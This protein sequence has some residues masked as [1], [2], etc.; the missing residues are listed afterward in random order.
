MSA[1]RAKDV[2][3]FAGLD[4]CD[5]TAFVEWIAENYARFG[6]ALE[7]VTDKSAQGSQFCKGFGGIGGVL[8]YP[9]ESATLDEHAEHGPG[10]DDDV[11]FTQDD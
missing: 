1:E 6:C 5:R 4:V 11:F 8:R 10:G 2:S 7:F 3:Q 9:V